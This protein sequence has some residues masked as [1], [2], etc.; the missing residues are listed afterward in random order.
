MRLLGWTSRYAWKYV[1][2][3][4][5]ARCKQ[6]FADEWVFMCLFAHIWINLHK[7]LFNLIV[8]FR[9]WRTSRNYL[10]HYICIELKHSFN[11][12]SHR[13]LNSRGEK[14]C[15]NQFWNEERTTVGLV[16]RCVHVCK[17]TMS[18]TPTNNM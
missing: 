2:P 12:M 9:N 8:I 1:T 14:N 16:S 17:M 10:N 3:L 11:F 13:L 7:F 6:I 4:C 15:A 5:G 18:S